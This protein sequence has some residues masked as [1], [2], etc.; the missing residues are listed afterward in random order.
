MTAA[1]RCSARCPQSQHSHLFR[2]PRSARFQGVRGPRAAVVQ[3]RFRPSAFHDPSHSSPCSSRSQLMPDG[4]GPHTR[5]DRL[6]SRCSAAAPRSDASAAGPAGTSQASSADSASQPGARSPASVLDQQGKALQAWAHQ[7]GVKASKLG[8][9]TFQ[10]GTSPV[11]A[12]PG[13]LQGVTSAPLTAWGRHQRLSFEVSYLFW[14][15]H[16]NCAHTHVQCM[17]AL[18]PQRA[19]KV[20]QCYVRC[21]RAEGDGSAG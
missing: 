1:R 9:A 12:P 21:C 16:T 6:S 20:I 18:C 17:A 4:S 7:A 5:T 14:P 10:G 13:S 11:T 2:R 8:P 3:Q 15:L 19:C